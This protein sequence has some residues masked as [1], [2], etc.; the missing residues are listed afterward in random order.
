MEASK[1]SRTKPQ[2]GATSTLDSLVS[3][4]T[5]TQT[6]EDSIKTALQKSME[7][8]KPSGTNPQDAAANILDN[9]VSVGTI[10]QTQE[11]EIQNTFENL[12]N[13][14]NEI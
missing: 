14:Q 5:I 2:D 1:S 12:M 4:G 9:L 3:A 11:D 13:Q 6:Q 10:T 7:V 8:N